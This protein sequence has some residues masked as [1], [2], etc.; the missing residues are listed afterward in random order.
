MWVHLRTGFPSF[1]LFQEILQ[2]ARE[3]GCFVYRAPVAKKEPGQAGTVFFL[4]SICSLICSK[5]ALCFV[6]L[7]CSH[8]IIINICQVCTADKVYMELGC[9]SVT[10]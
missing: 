6:A 5:A 3:Q 1:S 7:L 8:P 2:G 9:K 4:S 10:F